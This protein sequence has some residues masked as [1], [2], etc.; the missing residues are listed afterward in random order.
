MALDFSCVRLKPFQHQFE[1]TEWLTKQR[2]AF[3]ASEMRTGK[4][5]IVIDAMQFLYMQGLIDTVIV[6]VPAPVRDVWY[7]PGLG[8]LAKH[9]WRITP[10]VITEFHSNPRTWAWR[11]EGIA[12]TLKPMRWI[13]SNYEFVRNEATVDVLA[14]FAGPRTVIVGDESAFLRNHKSQQTEMFYK[15]RYRCGRVVLMNGTPI[16]HNPLDLFSQGNILHPSILECK[17]ITHFKNRYSIQEPVLGPGGKPVLDP[18]TGRAV[19]K[20]ASFINLDDLQRRFDRCTVRRMQAECLDLPPKLDPVSITPMLKPTTWRAYCA[21]RDELVVWL[22]SGEVASAMTAATKVM[23][24]AQITSG[25]LGGIED[26]GVMEE[27]TVAEGLLSSL[28]L[29]DVPDVPTKEKPTETT[30]PA[31]VPKAPIREFSR[32]KLDVLLWF[33]EKRWEEDPRAK[34]I[35][36]C[37]FRPELERTLRVA[38]EKFPN[39]IIAAIA[40][41]QSR[42]VRVEALGLLKPE[43]APP[44]PVLV[45]GIF[46][47]GS[48]GLDMCASHTSVTLSHDY[49]PGRVA[50]T[51]DRVYGPAQKHPV[52]YFN[53]LAVG[54]KGQKTIDH[55]IV[56]ARMRGE[57]VATWTASAWIKA[58]KSEAVSTVNIG[59]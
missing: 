22:E 59:T 15:L 2:F 21:M 58:I 32:E 55:A 4:T 44:G 56:E 47:T 41:G 12:G 18:K 30:V 33:L 49:S 7:D 52:A 6:M 10:A 23:R 17:Y 57:D 14:Q 50:Q 20:I 37:R 45:I 11:V 19:Q 9:L 13:I 36:W 35:V 43:T 39:V 54:P 31:H 16:Y 25:L 34:I 42:K 24:L 29:S 46:G 53:I 51:A 28:D 48:Y 27:D 5:K 40:G 3:I 1:D 8:E 38:R 26:S